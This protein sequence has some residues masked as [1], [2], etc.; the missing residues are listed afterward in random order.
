MKDIRILLG[1]C[2]VYGKDI[3]RELVETKRVSFCYNALSSFCC[4][5]ENSSII[6]FNQTLGRYATYEKVFDLNQ[7][8]ALGKNLLKKMAPYE[9]M[10]IKLGMRKTNFPIVNYEDEKRNYHKHLRFWN[11]VF[12]HYKINVVFFEEFP[13]V[14]YTY[15]I[16]CL[17]LVKGIP[18]RVCN[19]TSIPGIRVWGN[20][21]ENAGMDICSFYENIAKNMNVS[22]CVLEGPVLEFY[23]K[24]TRTVS[25]IKSDRKKTNFE[26]SE[27]KRVFDYMYGKYSGIN[28][29]L[30]SFRK[31]ASM[32]CK[33]L[34]GKKDWSWY[35]RN[36]IDILQLERE[37]SQIQLWKKQSA[38]TQ[39]EYNRIASE[40]DYD[41]QYIYFGMQL[42][43]EETTI[44]RAGVFSEQYLT[45]QLLARAAEK[46]GVF[47]YV[48]EHFVQAFRHKEEYE[49]LKKIPN[50]QLIKTSVSSFELMSNSIAVATQ[51][52]TCILEGVLRGKPVLV[53]SEGSFWKGMPA[54][55]E[56]IDEEQGAEVIRNIA[57]G[58][59]VPADE[60]KK[61]FYSIQKKSFKCYIQSDYEHQQHLPGHKESVKQWLMVLKD[62]WDEIDLKPQG[63]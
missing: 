4:E 60:V 47:V 18:L 40:P 9:S 27:K 50:V 13:H 28:G 12:E 3:A 25:E 21:I 48:K 30:K 56:V 37:C 31:K 10:A 38:M 23:E 54:M 35:H 53:T 52:G 5:N 62:F 36:Y 26:N 16:Y 24:Y 8:P 1:Y 29:F 57:N 19:Q 44:P 51:T 20:C 41:K 43:P 34:C 49:L 61:Y 22:D 7:L 17:A 46:N 14:P 55:F 32:L 63:V 45:V 33:V 6:N 42:T 2:P 59:T 39:K 58:F 15:V 11:Y